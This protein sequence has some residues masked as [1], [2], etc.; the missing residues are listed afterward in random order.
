MEKSQRDLIHGSASVG[1]GAVHRP[2]RCGLVPLTPPQ[3]LLI[4]VAVVVTPEASAEK[5]AL[6]LAAEFL[7]LVLYSASREKS[8]LVLAAKVPVEVPSMDKSALVLAAIKPC[9]P[10]MLGARCQRCNRSEKCDELQHGGLVSAPP[11]LTP[12]RAHM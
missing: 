5:S 9:E 10:A 12:N 3:R 4:A 1:Q 8:A 11:H 6:V 7:A 2:S